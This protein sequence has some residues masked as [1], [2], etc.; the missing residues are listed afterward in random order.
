MKSTKKLN[1]WTPKPKPYSSLFSLIQ[2]S[3]G[4][5]TVGN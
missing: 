5:P 4:N 3:A 2:Y 1:G